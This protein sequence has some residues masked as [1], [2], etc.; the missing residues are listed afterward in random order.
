LLKRILIDGYTLAQEARRFPTL[1]RSGIARRFEYALQ[2]FVVAPPV[3]PARG[4][5]ILVVDGV[6]FEFQRKEWVLYLMAVKPVR[7]RR[8]YFLDPVL[9][10]G[11][12]TIEA[13]YGAVETIPE[14]TRKQIR[15]LVSD[16]LRGFQGLSAHHDW[17]HQ[18][19]HFHLLSALVRG[20]GKRRYLTKG[21]PTRD[22]VLE[23][24]RIMLANESER[25]RT[26]ARVQLMR[27]GTNE[28]CPAYVRKHIIEFLE[29][30]RD[31]R[32]YL[33]HPRLN[34]PTTTN[35]MESSGKLVRKATRTA[36]TPESLR[37]R[38]VAFLRLKHSVICNGFDTPN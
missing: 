9:A 3:P 31:F 38:A 28:T 37:L 23:L 25:K 33:T 4:P 20:K 34:L 35:A 24:V 6:Y 22:R 15:G 32:S 14:K 21:S 13:W 2:S 5:Y 1:G 16:G 8:M 27:Y 10:K 36:R 17:V 19:C 12:E 18:R 11:R 7:S 29:R 30:E 26:R